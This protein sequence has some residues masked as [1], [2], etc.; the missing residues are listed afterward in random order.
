LTQELARDRIDRH[1]SMGAFGKPVYQSHVQLRAL[2]QQRRRPALAEYFARPHFDAESGEICWTTD[3]AGA[4]RRRAD[5][6]AG[7]R[8]Q[9]EARLQAVH[10]ELGTLAVD[11]RAQGGGAASFASV[12]E[13]AMKVPGDGDFVHFVGEQPV[14]TFWGFED[15]RGR[16]VEPARQVPTLQPTAASTAAA[17]PVVPAAAEP[18]AVAAA[19]VPPRRRAW[20]LWLLLLPLALALAWALSRCVPAG[21][22]ALGAGGVPLTEGRDAVDPLDI[23]PGALERGDLSFLDGV[24][25]LGERRLG[26]YEGRPDNVVGSD[27]VVLRFERDGSGNAHSVERLRR[28]AA[29]PDCTATL[30]AR[31]D[32]KKLYFERQACVAP[33]RPDLTVNGS[34]HECV[35]EPSGRTLCYGV[36]PDGV[37]WEAPLKRLR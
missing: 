37:R 10:D 2:L 23:P 30:A 13:Q 32:G 28:G 6:D 11:L 20:W 27:R 12:L 22:I 18:A 21:P 3:L 5:L 1:R 36:N 17:A 7:A 19:S 24:W 26:A 31:T 16:S 4:V 25:Q 35:R 9:A 33:G 15:A 14:I 34:R 29:V 8:V